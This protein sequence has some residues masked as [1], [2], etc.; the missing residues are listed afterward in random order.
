MR[1]DVLPCKMCACGECHRCLWYLW[2]T[3]SFLASHR[4]L[5]E[6]VDICPRTG[7]SEDATLCTYV[8][9]FAGH[10]GCSSLVVW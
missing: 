7:P 5:W 9:W 4:Q 3:L 2:K 8:R 10:H 6:G 1:D